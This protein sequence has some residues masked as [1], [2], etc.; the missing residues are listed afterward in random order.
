MRQINNFTAKEPDTCVKCGKA[1]APGQEIGWLRHAGRKGHFHVDCASLPTLEALTLVRVQ[2]TS[3]R[4]GYRYVRVK[5]LKGPV[6]LPE[7]PLAAKLGATANADGI[8]ITEARLSE[9][10]AEAVQ[11][12]RAADHRDGSGA[13]REQGA[14]S[15]RA[16]IA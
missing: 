9:L 4:Q 2:D 5:D 11:K 8:F 14:R 6:L 13:G 10:I 12:D 16:A 1:I 3:T 7:H 15:N